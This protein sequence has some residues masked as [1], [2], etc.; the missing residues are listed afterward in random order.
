LSTEPSS[1][2]QQ[3]HELAASL[4]CFTEHE[5]EVLTGWNE[6]TRRAYRHR[7]MGPA[8]VKV[9][10]F[11]FYPRDMFMDWMNS[12]VRQPNRAAGVEAL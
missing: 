4:N 10:K 2:E 5:I 6:G 3:L 1:T 7:H 12:R 11:L 8:S 9:G